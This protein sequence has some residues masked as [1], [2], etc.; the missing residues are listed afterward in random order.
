MS[1]A[2]LQF[3]Q[4]YVIFPTDADANAVTNSKTA[5]WLTLIFWNL[6]GQTGKIAWEESNNESL[7]KLSMSVQLDCMENKNE[8]GNG[9][10]LR[11]SGRHRHRS[12]H[13]H[14]G[15]NYIKM[16]SAWKART[17]SHSVSPITFA[18]ASERLRWGVLRWDIGTCKWINSNRSGHFCTTSRHTIPQRFTHNFCPSVRTNYVEAF[19]AET[20]GRAN[21]STQIVQRI[22][23]WQARTQSHSVWP[24]TFVQASEQIT[25]RRFTLRHFP[26]RRSTKK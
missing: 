26:L 5:G 14:T 13:F 10:A 4:A 12:C 11:F 18:Q 3:Q 16:F 6:P 2:L 7:L 22:S 20:L 25:L 17:Q 1:E 21:E 9:D 15:M 19:Y 8:T 23:T 24:T